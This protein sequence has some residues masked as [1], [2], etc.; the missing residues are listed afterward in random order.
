MRANG[1]LADPNGITKEEL[2][3]F[4]RYVAKERIESEERHEKE[5][6]EIKKR[7][8]MQLQMYDIMEQQPRLCARLKMIVPKFPVET[9]LAI[10]SH[11]SLLHQFL[12]NPCFHSA[13][14]S[15]AIGKVTKDKILV[16]ITEIFLYGVFTLAE[17]VNFI[18][19]I[20]TEDDDG[21]KVPYNPK[22]ITLSGFPQ[23]IVFMCSGDDKVVTK[24]KKY[25]E[26]HFKSKVQINNDGD[27][28][29]VVIQSPVVR[30]LEESQ[31]MFEEF[32][33]Y[34][35]DREDIKPLGLCQDITNIDDVQYMINS[36]GE[37]RDITKIEELMERL[38]GF[39]M[40]VNININYGG[41]FIVGDNNVINI[42]KDKLKTDTKSWIKNNPPKN[43]EKKTEY[44]ERYKS[45]SV[46]VMSERIFAQLVPSIAGCE[47]L[48]TGGYNY[49]VYNK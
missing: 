48:K 25:C 3:D 37:H 23:R 12:Q 40:T 4:K 34:V 2:E 42:G 19:N 17:Y 18:G 47:S 6:M 28:T 7:R 46:N 22:Q 41:N 9:A 8:E 35:S 24:I 27:K 21:N 44:Y 13:S 16:Y 39:P 43:R 20:Q 26:I 36:I 45:S 32:C 11:K 14:L 49:W 15:D 33:K 31:K 1:D 30:N 38:S 5:L 29:D 10:G